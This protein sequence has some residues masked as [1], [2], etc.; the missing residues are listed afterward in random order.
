MD[1]PTASRLPARGWLAGPR[2]I[3]LPAVGLGED[4][5]NGG[6]DRVMCGP[7]EDAAG[8]DAQDRVAPG[9]EKIQPG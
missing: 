7:G 9:C 8:L 5:L 6:P 2:G 1:H 3:L 4:E